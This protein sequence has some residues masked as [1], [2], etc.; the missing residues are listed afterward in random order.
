MWGNWNVGKCSASCGEAV[1]TDTRTCIRGNCGGITSRIVDCQLD[2]CPG[3][4]ERIILLFEIELV[5]I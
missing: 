3:W 1:R 5:I 2:V 4:F